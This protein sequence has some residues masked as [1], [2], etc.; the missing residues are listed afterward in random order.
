[1]EDQKVTAPRLEPSRALLSPLNYFGDQFLRRSV[2][3]RK[4]KKI[5]N[6]L[7]GGQWTIHQ[8]HLTKVNGPPLKKI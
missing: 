1:M 6:R 3:V 2:F 4:T 5:K 8:A 7:L